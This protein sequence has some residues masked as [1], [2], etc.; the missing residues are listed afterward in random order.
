M[1]N[2][3]IT[4]VFLSLQA[5]PLAADELVYDYEFKL[6]MVPEQVLTANHDLAARPT[7]DFAI[8]EIVTM[9]VQFMDSTKL[10]L[11]A[12]G[13]NTR[14]RKKKEGKKFELTYKKRYPITTTIA[15]AIRQAAQDGFDGGNKYEAQVEWG[16]QKQTM[17]FSL[18]KD[19]K[20]DA[21][22]NMA[23]PELRDAQKVCRDNVPDKLDDWHAPSWGSN[24]LNNSHAFGP[25]NATRYV[26][27]WEGTKIY[28]EVWQ[29]RAKNG[30]GYEY[31]VEISFKADNEES[32]IAL[33]AKLIT[34]LKN[35]NWFLPEDKLKTQMILERY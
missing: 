32:G 26:G 35:R 6:F 21:Y 18:N 16:Y 22:G 4:L 24:I 12:E 20:L 1:R 30:V 34:F 31:P 2:L 27:V 3:L 15:A 8:S 11:N 23:M 7:A 33:Q 14:I 13:W 29:I 10:D 28:I 19:V 17:S 5:V 25:V 9:R